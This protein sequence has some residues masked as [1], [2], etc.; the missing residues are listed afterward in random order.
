MKLSIIIP[1]YNVDA[2]I[3][4]CIISI[5]KQNLDPNMFELIIIDDGS[6]DKSPQVVQKYIETYSNITLYSQKNKG[7]G[8]ARNQGIKLSKGEY[9][10]F[11]DGDD[12]LVNSVF[13][14]LLKSIEEFNLDILGFNSSKTAK[15][16]FF[17]TSTKPISIAPDEIMDGTTFIAQNNYRNEVWWYIIKKDF[18]TNSQITFEEGRMLEDV[19]FTTALILRSNRIVSLKLDVHRYFIREDSIL[20]L[21]NSNHYLHLIDDY[22]N[23][24]YEFENVIK[25]LEEIGTID[26]KCLQR[27]RS[28][29]QSFTF[30][31]IVRAFKSNM[32]YKVLLKYLKDIKKIKAYPLDKFLGYDYNGVTYLILTKI[33]DNRMTLFISFILFRSLRRVAAP[34]PVRFQ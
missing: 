10:Y 3:E 13:D 17:F 25:H 12:Y 21:K 5:L 33:F 28:K 1:M 32:T 14:L 7:V 20:N 8:A 26:F 24:I 9:I 15:S 23:V 30:F 16:E 19:I 29:Q 22:K 31:L 18:L 11:I 34:L 4:R 6:S 2:Y 27:M